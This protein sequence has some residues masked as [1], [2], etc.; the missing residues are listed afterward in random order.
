[1]IE[2]G[3]LHRFFDEFPGDQDFRQVVAVQEIAG[4]G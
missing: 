2:R 3:G 1:V 4:I